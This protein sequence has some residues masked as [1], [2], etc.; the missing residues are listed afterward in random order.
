[1]LP[2]V[3]IAEAHRRGILPADDIDV[4]LSGDTEGDAATL[5]ELIIRIAQRERI[6]VANAQG[7]VDFQLTRGL[8]G[9]TT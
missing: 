4:F 5:R 1:M 7:F 2:V 6:P 8:L 3:Q 9:L